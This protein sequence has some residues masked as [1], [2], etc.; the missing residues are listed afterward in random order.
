MYIQIEIQLQAVLFSEKRK[1]L[2]MIQQVPLFY[3]LFY[4]V[5]LSVDLDH[6]DGSVQNSSNSIAN[7][8][9][10]L[11]SS[12]KPSIWWLPQCQWRRL[13]LKY[14]GKFCQ[15][16]TT[17]KHK[18]RTFYVSCGM[19]VLAVYR[20]LSARLQC[21]GNG[22]TAVLHKAINIW[23][24][25]SAAGANIFHLDISIQVNLWYMHYFAITNVWHTD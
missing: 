9:E 21:I 13:I 16:M 22:D 11:Q 3:G 23:V 1:T 18:A 4:E 8:L 25:I 15:Y 2:N 5:L 14:Y 12:T 7:A 24:C 17:S 19:Y 10:L 20:W 6:M